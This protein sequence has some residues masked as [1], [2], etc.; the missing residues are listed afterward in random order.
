[1]TNAE[2]EQ[3]IRDLDSNISTRS[4]VYEK[5]SEEFRLRMTD[6]QACHQTNA[7]RTGFYENVIRRAERL[8]NSARVRLI[9]VSYLRQV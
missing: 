8:L 1:M 3:I 9:Y 7:F 5:V 6:G 4:G 2:V